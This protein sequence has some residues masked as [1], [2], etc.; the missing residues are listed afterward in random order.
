MPYLTDTEELALEQGIDRGRLEQAR[1]SI[2]EVLQTRFGS[3]P[4]EVRERL[5]SSLSTEELGAI[6]R[7]AIICRSAEELFVNS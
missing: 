5:Q 1:E 4:V 2:L 6:L 7:R 3:F